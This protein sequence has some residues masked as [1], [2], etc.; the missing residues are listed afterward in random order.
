MVRRALVPG[1]AATALAFIAGYFFAGGDVATSAALGVAVVVANFA[2]N[3][4]SLAWA[5]TI[6]VTAVQV[7]ALVGFV[8][9][10]GI[11]A[12]LMF[13]LDTMAWFSP[14]AFGL[15]VMPATLV[16]LAFE[17]MLVLRRHLGTALDLPADPAAVAAA[18]RLAAKEAAG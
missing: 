16:L 15:A 18:Q 14:L 10:L 1:A 7:V 3:G 11:I 2:A 8:V 4:L 13:A 12:G 6:S 5:S 17:A 9:R